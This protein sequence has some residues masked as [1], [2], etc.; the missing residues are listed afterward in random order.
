MSTECSI[1]TE[2]V[3]TGLRK[4]GHFLLSTQYSVLDSR[5]DWFFEQD[6]GAVVMAAPLGGK[7]APHRPVLLDETQHYLAPEQGVSLH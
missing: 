4:R 7:G 3:G 5:T 6:H 1:K 2:V